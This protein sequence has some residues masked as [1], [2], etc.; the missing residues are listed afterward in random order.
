[1]I[2]QASL[3]L[4]PGIDL[5]HILPTMIFFLASFL[6]FLIFSF[7]SRPHY[8]FQSPSVLMSDIKFE[9]IIYQCH[10]CHCSLGRV[11]LYTKFNA[12][13][14]MIFITSNKI[15]LIKEKKI[16]IITH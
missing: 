13:L 16:W 4:R 7:L 6:S 1:M 3:A 15:L 12:Y 11:E 5:L 2:V 14:T 9:Y 10:V 8:L